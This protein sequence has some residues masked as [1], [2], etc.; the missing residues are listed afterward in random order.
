MVDFLKDQP[1]AMSLAAK[2]LTLLPS[3]GPKINPSEFV[4]P[5]AGVSREKM[6]EFIEFSNGIR[7][8]NF[9]NDESY[10]IAATKKVWATRRACHLV[11]AVFMS[12]SYIVRADGSDK[13]IKGNSDLFKL[14]KKPNPFDTWE[15]MLY[16]WAHH[17]KITGKAF[18]LKDELN[19]MG[20]PKALYALLPQYMDPVY[21]HKKLISE[22]V[23]KI[24]GKEI[25]Y[26]PE[27]IIYFKKPNP[28]NH[29][30]GLG[31]MEPAE[32]VFNSVINRNTLNEKFIERGAA[33]SGVLVKEEA[34]EDD[35]DWEMLKK[36]FEE[37][38]SGKENAGKVV[39]LNGKWKWE[40]MGLTPQEMQN[41]ESTKFDIEQIFMI[42]GV[43]LSVAGVKDSANYATARQEEKNFKQFECCPLLDMF[44]AR[45]NSEVTE[46]FN[47]D[48]KV[49][50]KMS[51]L[52]DVEQIGKDYEKFVEKGAMTPNEFRV[53]AELPKSDNP[54]LDKFYVSSDRIPMEMAGK[55]TK[56]TPPAKKSVEEEPEQE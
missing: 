36:K 42:H 5:K 4:I 15:E 18:W 52:V 34:V 43:P 45:F 9:T 51:G 48:W 30:L 11:G 29:V 22:Y 21:D 14:L 23:Y 6:R 28:R 12:T 33:P 47:K 31:D 41:M 46:K 3:Y 1:Q 17:M 40:K 24:N 54:L 44:L 26:K 27:E 2:L 16:L 10:L 25:R 19:A 32:S 13:E 55:D 50:Y 56:T 35:D 20:Q 39:F 37:K 7:L 49:F 53:M 38:Y 8:N